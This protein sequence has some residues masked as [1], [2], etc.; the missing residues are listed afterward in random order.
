VDGP[1]TPATSG[2]ELVWLAADRAMVA[3]EEADDPLAVAAA[4]WYYAALYRSAGQIDRAL[5]TALDAAALLDP[6]A[7]VEQRAR[8][9]RLQ[10]SPALSEATAGNAGNARGG[11]WDR[12]DQ[13]ATAFGSDY[14]HPWLRFGRAD[15]DANAVWINRLFRPGQAL[16]RADALDLSAQPGPGVRALRLLDIAE[17]H[18]LLNEHAGVIYMIRRAHRESAETVKFELTGRAMLVDL[19]ERR[20][21]VRDDA[22]EL[23]TT[24]GI[25][26]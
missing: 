18:N 4:A 20:S 1:A 9:G 26:I 25:P 23:A 15:V 24:L 16:R 6:A 5:A 10:M 14:Y 17:A 7:G 21:S 12:A 13:A 3:A 8:W 2:A 22:R 11:I 19:S